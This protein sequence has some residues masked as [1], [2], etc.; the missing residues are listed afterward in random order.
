MIR[1]TIRVSALA[2]ALAI[3]TGGVFAQDNQALIDAL[4]KKG[5]LSQKEAEKIEAEVSKNPAVQPEQAQSPIKLAPWIKELKLSGDLRL[6]WQGDQAQ[7]QE[8][9]SPLPTGGPLDPKKAGSNVSQRSRWRFRLRLNADFKFDN[10]FF[11]GVG[12]TTNSQ[13][14]SANQTYTAAYRNYNIFINKAF[15]GW[16]G[17]PGITILA[18]KFDNPFYTTDLFWDTNV[19]PNGLAERLDFAKLFGWSA[20]G[21]EWGGYSKEGKGAPPPAPA[22]KPQ[23]SFELSLIAGQFVFYDNNEYNFDSDLNTDSFQFW[24]QLLTRYKTPVFSA[25]WGPSLFITNAAAVGHDSSNPVD[26]TVHTRPLV[27][28]GADVGRGEERD[29]FIVMS[30]GDIGFKVGNIPIKLFW[31]S[32]YNFDGGQRF[33]LLGA[34]GNA[35]DP[36]GANPT[37]QT[38]DRTGKIVTETLPRGIYSRFNTYT[39]TRGGVSITQTGIN[40]FTRVGGQFRDK[41]AWLVG[42]KIGDNKKAGDWSIFGDYRQVGIAAID[43][44]TGNSDPMN[45]RLN[46]QG[47]NMGIL[48]NVT[49]FFILG[50]DGRIDWNLKQLY[51]GQATRGSGIADYNSWNYVRV[52]AILKF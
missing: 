39:Q 48:Y 37:F 38:F 43:P 10:G 3:T 46:M 23:S 28:S 51:G 24:T 18:G 33:N 30:P 32:A 15:L 20:A 2:G 1:R 26:G 12:L 13:N 44:N 7:Q 47:F 6:R 45:G 21:E 8:P 14:D 41:L 40:P 35:G 31:D 5:V 16:N 11:G 50:V 49:D 22:P 25:T 29:L 34:P 42:I 27:F 17:V 36:A 52:N 4:V 19:Y 9:N